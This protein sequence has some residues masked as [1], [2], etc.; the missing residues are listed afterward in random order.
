MKWKNRGHEFDHMY[1][2]ISEKKGFYLFGAG[3]YGQQFLHVFE[4]EIP[5]KGF[6]DNDPVKQGKI[7]RGMKCYSPEDV[8]L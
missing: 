2:E 6:I 4:K 7:I 3:D 8:T 5:I 1:Q